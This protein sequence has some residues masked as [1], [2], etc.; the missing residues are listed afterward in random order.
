MPE[1]HKCIHNGRRSSACITCKGPSEH[2]HH[3]R[4]F[5]SIDAG[6]P[7]LTEDLCTH[8]S[9]DPEPEHDS[10]SIVSWF[11][12]LTQR[13]REALICKLRDPQLS[14]NEIGRQMGWSQRTIS[15]DLQ[16]IVNSIPETASSGIRRILGQ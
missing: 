10:I 12:G 14:I 1:C 11:A 16:S 3:G 7:E 5:V 9:V 2:N 4:S 8:P 6:P 13:Q 15:R